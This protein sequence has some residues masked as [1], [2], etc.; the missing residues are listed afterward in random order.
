MSPV[1]LLQPMELEDVIPLIG[2]KTQASEDDAV[3]RYEEEAAAGG[4]D[5]VP[6]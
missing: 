1:E 3:G 2:T 4:E 6:W 5:D